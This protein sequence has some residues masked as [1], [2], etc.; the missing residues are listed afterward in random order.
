MRISPTW[1]YWVLRKLR[2][3]TEMLSCSRKMLF[4]ISLTGKAKCF[5]AINLHENDSYYT[6]VD[7]GRASYHGRRAGR[8]PKHRVH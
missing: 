7:D 5:E 2:A 1:R 8:L 4:L 6:Q 3:I